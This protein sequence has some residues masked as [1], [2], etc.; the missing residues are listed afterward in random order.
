MTKIIIKC[1]LKPWFYFCLM[2]PSGVITKGFFTQVQHCSTRVA[3]SLILLLL[4]SMLPFLRFFE[5]LIW[6]DTVQVLPD[7]E[8]DSIIGEQLCDVMSLQSG[9][10][11]EKALWLG[12]SF[13]GSALL[14]GAITFTQNFSSKMIPG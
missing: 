13:F 5:L 1:I 12:H 3:P 2:A 8:E 7:G 14:T 9:L 10:E 6:P 4:T 11:W